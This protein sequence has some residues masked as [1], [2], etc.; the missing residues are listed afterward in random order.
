MSLLRLVITLHLLLLPNVMAAPTGPQRFAA[1]ARHSRPSVTSATAAPPRLAVRTRRNPGSGSPPAFM[2]RLYEQLTDRHGQ[3][4]QDV[5]N[6]LATHS[7]SIWSLQ[8]TGKYCNWSH[9]F[10]VK[11]LD[12]VIT[13]LLGPD[14]YA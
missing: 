12:A 4:R 5:G 14:W 6:G 7:A 8:N 11:T 13:D 2:M 9:S 1:R 3:L 10:C